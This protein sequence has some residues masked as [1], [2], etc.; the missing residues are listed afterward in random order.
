MPTRK[1]PRRRGKTG[2]NYKKTLAAVRPELAEKLTRKE[3]HQKHREALA[4]AAES[5]RSIIS[6]E[7][8][9]R[10]DCGIA[11]QAR[12][13][14]RECERRGISIA[15]IAIITRVG[16]LARFTRGDAVLKVQQ[17]ARIANTLGLAL[18]YSYRDGMHAAKN[19]RHPN[20]A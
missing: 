3:L 14:L 19:K 11:E 16:Q 15:E 18:V 6:R 17:I 7:R 10:D 8:A 20:G 5:A 2:F 12:I 4:A 13:M 9:Q 1:S